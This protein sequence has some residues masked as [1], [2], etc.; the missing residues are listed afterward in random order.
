MGYSMVGTYMEEFGRR[1]GRG[2]TYYI[3]IPEIKKKKSWILRLMSI[4]C[5]A[6][7]GLNDICGL[8]CHLR[9]W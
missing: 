9:A 7:K 3:I 6:S 1:K 2:K 5:A 8:S 4:A